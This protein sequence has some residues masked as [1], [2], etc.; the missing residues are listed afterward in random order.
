MSVEPGYGG[1][2]F[3]ESIYENSRGSDLL[4]VTGRDIPIS[5]DGGINR[6]NGEEAC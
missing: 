3:E 5:V 1:Q 4:D 2:T 6:K